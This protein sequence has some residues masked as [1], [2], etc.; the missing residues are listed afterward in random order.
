[1]PTRN[2]SQESVK[3][4]RSEGRKEREPSLKERREALKKMRDFSGDEA[5][6]GVAQKLATAPQGETK[7]FVDFIKTIKAYQGDQHFNKKGYLERRKAIYD[8]YNDLPKYAKDVINA[9]KAAINK[10][11]RGATAKAEA[12]PDGKINASFEAKLTSVGVWGNDAGT[13][14]E[15]TAKDVESFDEII[16]FHKA[17]EVATALSG[18][19]K[20]KGSTL[21]L[22][23]ESYQ[24]EFL[25]TNIKWKD[26][27]A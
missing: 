17:W 4:I 5:T 16:S 11:I 2:G 13:R 6:N 9:P 21:D 24:D 1:M 3:T 20:V 27:V 15:Y 10:I 19:G 12:G 25:V 18:T 7:A 23:D 22:T 26:G 14:K 8:A